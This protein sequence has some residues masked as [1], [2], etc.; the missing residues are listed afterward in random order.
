MTEHTTEH[1]KGKVIVITGA[2]GGFGRLVSTKTAAMGAQVVCADVKAAELDI[3]VESIV[4]QGGAATALVTDVTELT[5]MQALA[6]HALDTYGRI[7]V[8]IN[9]AGTMPLAFHADHAEAV[10]AW[11]RCIDINIKGV[12]NGIIAAHD[13]MIEQGRGHI[14]NLSSIYSNFPV[15]GAGVY[16][17]TKAAVNFLSD[18]LRVE[19]QGKIKVTVVKPTGVPATG[20]GAG[21]VNPDAVVGILGQNAPGYMQQMQAHAEGTLSSESADANSIEYYALE[22]GYLADQIVSVI[23]QP[24]G[25]N[26]SEITVRASGDGYIL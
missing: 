23:N 26:V 25:V 1:M 7:D 14:I 6:G 13:P 2:A 4:A 18:S 5:Q 9:N 8:W 19:S 17:A 22:P 20:L 15:V 11:N 3:T 16:G 24:W 12:M 10:P 21:I